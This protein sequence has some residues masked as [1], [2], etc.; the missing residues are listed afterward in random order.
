[1]MPRLR[2]WQNTKDDKQARIPPICTSVDI[3]GAN[4][5]SKQNDHADQCGESAPAIT[6]MKK[7]SMSHFASSFRV[8]G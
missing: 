4:W 1:M 7:P 3:L 2:K 8:A 5:I 6:V